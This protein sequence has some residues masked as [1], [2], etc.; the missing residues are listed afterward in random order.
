MLSCNC[1]LIFLTS[2][3]SSHMFIYYVISVVFCL[4]M[5][6]PICGRDYDYEGSEL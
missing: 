3:I 5:K 6:L 4:L 2:Y 1:S